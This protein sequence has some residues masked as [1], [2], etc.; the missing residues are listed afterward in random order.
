MKAECIVCDTNVLISA[1]IVSQGKPRVLELVKRNGRLLM[2]A[3]AMTELATRLQRSKFDRYLSV[4]GRR[5]FLDE[6][7]AV[8]EIVSIAGTLAVCRDVDDNA[9]LETAIAGQAD[10]LVTGDKDLLVLRPAGEN[11]TVSAQEEALYERGAILRPAEFLTL[12]QA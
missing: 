5:I 7:A 2:S 9:I 3:A 11:A 4:E 8:V 10:S 1:A 12:L 6:I